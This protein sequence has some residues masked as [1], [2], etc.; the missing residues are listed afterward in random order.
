ME[1]EI[2]VWFDTD[3][4]SPE[5]YSFR[6]GRP[7]GQSISRMHPAGMGRLGGWIGIVL[8]ARSFVG[9]GE[10]DRL[11]DLDWSGSGQY[12]A[13]VRKAI[14]RVMS[15]AYDVFR[16]LIAVQAGV[17]RRDMAIVTSFRK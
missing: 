15:L 10:A 9:I 7:L 16:A 17:E 1:K 2:T 8:H 12:F 13:A 5:Q 3:D 6:S 14:Y 11:R 4:I